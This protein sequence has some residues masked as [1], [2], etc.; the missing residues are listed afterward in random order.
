MVWYHKNKLCFLVVRMVL[1]TKKSANHVFEARTR[2]T[3]VNLWFAGED[4]NRKT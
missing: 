3:E 4:K 2:R 1:F